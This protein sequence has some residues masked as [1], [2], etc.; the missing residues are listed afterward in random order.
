MPNYTMRCDNS[1]LLS[2]VILL[3]DQIKILEEENKPVKYLGI[4]LDTNLNLKFHIEKTIE[5]CRMNS[6]SYCHSLLSNLYTQNKEI[7]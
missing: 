3:E 2:L 1:S 4:Y 5:K 6:E 7:L